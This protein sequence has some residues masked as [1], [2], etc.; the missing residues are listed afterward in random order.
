[1]KSANA[2][3]KSAALTETRFVSEWN[4]P[5]WSAM[6]ASVISGLLLGAGTHAAWLADPPNEYANFLLLGGVAAGAFF[7]FRIGSGKSEVRVGDAGVAVHQ[8]GEVTR[9]LWSEI[10]SIR[11]ADAHLVLSGA[12]TTLRVKSQSHTRAIRAIL[13]EAAER[14]PKILDVPA[15]L[16][17]ELPTVTGDN[18]SPEPVESLQIA[19]KRCL[20]TNQLLTFERDARLCPNCTSIYHREHVPEVCGVC[21]RPLGDAAVKIAN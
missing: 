16:V 6:G 19:G 11:Y 20:V 18:P 3:S 15:K 12:S 17:D 14:L 10:Q 2:E 5:D 9:L 8:G 13:R 1:M 4:R 21:E 7:A